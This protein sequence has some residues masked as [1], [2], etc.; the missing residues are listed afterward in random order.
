MSLIGQSNV[1]AR[2]FGRYF[3]AFGANLT[4]GLRLALPLPARLQHLSPS[5][6]QFIGLLCGVWL[7]RA[8]DDWIDTG[9]DA[10]FLPWGVLSQATQS[11]FWVATL[12]IIVMIDR[13]PSEFLRFAVAMASVSITVFLSWILTTNLWTVVHR[14][15]YFAS[16]NTL[17]WAFG[18]WEVALFARVVSCVYGTNWRRTLCYTIA[19]G[20]TVYALAI[21]LPHS[22]L[23]VATRNSADAVKVDVESTYYA[24]AN[25]LRQSLYAV[26]PQRPGVV[27]LYFIG[28]AAYANQDVFRREIEQATIIFEQRFDS[29]GRTVALINNLD[30]LKSVP[31]ANRHNLEQALRGLA[32]RIDREEDIVVVFL[33]SHG[34][35]DATIAVELTGFGF[36]DLA[37]DEVRTILDDNAIKWRI[38]IVSACYSG[39]FIERLASPTTLVITA[40][41]ADRSSFGCS[42]KNEWTYFGEAYFEQAL[43]QTR[44]FI[45]AFELA[46]ET[47]HQRETAEG[48]EASNPQ[49]AIGDE[50]AAYLEQHGL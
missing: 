42:H 46:R 6:G 17:W 4:V 7:L 41:S 22:P 19:Y 38:I 14:T 2:A 34:A 8:A 26:S 32:Q 24:Q 27:D 18:A 5:L 43:R 33:T 44:S 20:G 10:E 25:L 12:A 28:F 1:I 39:S 37:A 3:A 47:I 45:T 9:L 50:I 36:N 23:F 49:I 21:F 30:T 13:R 11:Y 40:S 15:S 29:I 31:L 16:Y 35:E 48:K